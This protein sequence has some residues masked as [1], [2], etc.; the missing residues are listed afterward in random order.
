M[1]R[2]GGGEEGGEE[3]K[4]QSHG[5]VCLPRERCVS[6]EGEKNEERTQILT[7]WLFG[8]E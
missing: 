1:E 3:T 6:Y 2:E 8:N 5:S 7:G 4:Q